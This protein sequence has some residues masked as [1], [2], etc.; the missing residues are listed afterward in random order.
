[1]EW[2]VAGL[3]GNKV[4]LGEALGEGCQPV[5]G[6]FASWGCIVKEFGSWFVKVSFLK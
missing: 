3:T 6:I 4:P 2:S 1:M 5:V